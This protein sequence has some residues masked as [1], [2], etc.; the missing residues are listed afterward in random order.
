[1][2][3]VQS[4]PLLVPGFSAHY[5]SFI[6]QKSQI[7]S[8]SKLGIGEYNPCWGTSPFPLQTR[9]TRKQV[10]CSQNT[11]EEETQ[12]SSDSHSHSKREGK[13][14]PS[15]FQIQPGSLHAVSRPRTDPLWLLVQLSALKALPSGAP[16][17]QV[18]MSLRGHYSITI[19]VIKFSF[20]FYSSSF[21][22]GS[23]VLKFLHQHQ[24]GGYLPLH[25]YVVS[26][27]GAHHFQELYYISFHGKCK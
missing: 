12:E 18:W 22:S 1:M 4:P 19:T 23:S 26:T 11:M 16:R 27:R 15:R 5:I 25:K 8:K 6:S 14:S 3:K 20:I 2:C 17:I 13:K 24:S 21:R 7:S 9:E 10:L